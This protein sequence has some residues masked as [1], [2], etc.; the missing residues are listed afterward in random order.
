MS[1]NL[2]NSAVPTGLF[3]QWLSGK[4]SS[5]NAGFAGGVV[6][7]P[8]SGRS[9]GAGHGHPLQYSCLDYPID[10]GAWQATFLWSQ[11]VGH[12]WS[13]FTCMHT[14]QPYRRNKECGLWMD[15]A[16]SFGSLFLW[17]LMTVSN[18][19]YFPVLCFLT[20]SIIVEIFQNNG[21]VKED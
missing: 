5:C 14:W 7:I 20:S 19:P 4:E 15:D 16:K 13:E 12:D 2:E 1:A 17:Q 10:R 21:S 3:P 8:G 6:S 11:R 9:L 18:P